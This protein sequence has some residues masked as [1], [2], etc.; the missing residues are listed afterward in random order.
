M[1]FRGWVRVSDIL[2]YN[3]QLACLG[4]CTCAGKGQFWGGNL[5]WGRSRRR[6]WRTSRRP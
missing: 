6:K 5:G 4:A 1:K 2:D 3:L